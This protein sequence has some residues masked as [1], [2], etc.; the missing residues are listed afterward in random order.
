[1][2]KKYLL[3]L[4]F[5]IL[6][7]CSKEPPI[8]I[9]EVT[10]PTSET[11]IDL[12]AEEFSDVENAQFLEFTLSDQQI[13]LNID[14][15]PILANFLKN[16]NDRDQAIQNM[17]LTQIL[18]DKFDSFFLLSFACQDNSCSYVLINTESEYSKL[19]ADQARTV[20]IN[21]SPDESYLLIQFERQ[22]RTNP[23]VTNK[24]FVLDLDTWEEII[25]TFEDKDMTSLHSFRWPILDAEWRNDDELEITLP[26]L[27]IP[28]TSTLANWSESEDKPEKIIITQIN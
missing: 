12:V 1:M 24:L 23:R 14:K 6:V 11:S 9:Q 19:L 4:L 25:L 7:G 20:K 10:D 16:H 15:I 26:D 5:I 2:Y 3:S 18:K 8:I 17:Q 22:L 28:S 27:E 13:S 21:V